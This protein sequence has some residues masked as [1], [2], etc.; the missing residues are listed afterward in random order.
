MGKV[1]LLYLETR[2]NIY[3]I[4]LKNPG[5]HMRE[6]SRKLDM[7]I[8]TLS[9]HLNNFEQRGLIT[10]KSRSGYKRLYVSFKIGKKEKEILDIF[11]QE[12]PRNILLYM[13]FG[14][15]CSKMELSKELEKHH[16]T[17]DFHLKKLIDLDIIKVAT[18]KNGQIIMPKGSINHKRSSN[19][20]IYIFKDMSLFYTLY[21]L[22][23]VYNGSLPEKELVTRYITEGKNH[24]SKR[25][26]S[27][28]NLVSA[29]NDAIEFAIE[30]F[31]DIFPHPYHV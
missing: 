4:I 21:D 22:L 8:T 3:N 18:V 29:P 11:R 27:G 24:L 16:T 9:Y 10:A 14:Y 25:K 23:I 7:P 19:E 12:V 15:A 31:F 2:R 30:V 28:Y 20:I 6:L 17:I 5:L 26:R 13:M 1:D